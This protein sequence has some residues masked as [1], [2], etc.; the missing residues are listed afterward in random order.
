[1]LTKSSG[2]I[3]KSDIILPAI[4]KKRMPV[5]RRGKLYKFP[6]NIFLFLNI[7]RIDNYYL[8]LLL[9][10]LMHFPVD[11]VE[12]LNALVFWM[13]RYVGDRQLTLYR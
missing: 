7:T 11:Q 5:I 9:Y 3:P 13:M 12:I 4:N 8:L 1:M 6:I 10:F 2:I